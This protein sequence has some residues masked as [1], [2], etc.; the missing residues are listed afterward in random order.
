[1]LSRLHGHVECEESRWSRHS[2]DLQR[3]LDEARRQLDERI[4]RESNCRQKGHEDSE[5]EED[6]KVNNDDVEASS[7]K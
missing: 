2:A 1:M 3:Q 4:L 6:Y 5:D 7:V